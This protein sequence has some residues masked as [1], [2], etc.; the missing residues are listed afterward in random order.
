MIYPG[1]HRC[2]SPASRFL[3]ITNSSFSLNKQSREIHK[4]VSVSAWPLESHN[5][6]VAPPAS[7]GLNLNQKVEVAQ[8][9]VL[10]AGQGLWS[11]ELIPLHQPAV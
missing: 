3:L 8:H 7:L 4:R 11:L 9:S 6:C 1:C 2:R 5:S 10:F